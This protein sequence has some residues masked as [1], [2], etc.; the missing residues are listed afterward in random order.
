MFSRNKYSFLSLTFVLLGLIASNCFSGTVIMLNGTSSAGKSSIARDLQKA[1][2]PD[3]IEILSIDIIFYEVAREMIAELGHPV[4]PDQSWEELCASLPENLE[5]SEKDM[6]PRAEKKLYEKVKKHTA[7]DTYVIIDAVMCKPQHAEV[8]AQKLQGLDVQNVLVYCT[9]S[10][11]LEHVIQRNKGPQEEEHRP[12]TQPF[13][14]FFSMFAIQKDELCTCIEEI[15]VQ[16]LDALINENF[17][18]TMP[19]MDERDL[20]R[21]KKLL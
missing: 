4:D 1:L 10:K 5:L 6:V 7:E 20:K 17:V 3:K 18:E 19:T 12:L 21:V 13:F 15:N 8:W 9:P 16:E 11:L 2:V 14:Q